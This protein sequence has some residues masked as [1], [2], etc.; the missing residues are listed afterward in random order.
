MNFGN[1]IFSIGLASILVLPTLTFKEIGDL[2]F[3]SAN[4]IYTSFINIGYIRIVIYWLY[5]GTYI[6]V[7]IYIYNLYNIYI[8][9]I[10]IY[11]CIV[12]IYAYIY[13]IYIYI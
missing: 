12:Y 5:I 8:I 10:Y 6:Y 4:L 13:Y 7:Y 2:C 3:I 1:I 9:H 11:I